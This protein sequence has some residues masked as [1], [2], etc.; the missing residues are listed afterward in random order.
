MV[1]CEVDHLV[2]HQGFISVTDCQPI[3]VGHDHEGRRAVPAMNDLDVSILY[4]SRFFTSC[5]FD[6]SHFTVKV[7]KYPVTALTPPPPPAPP[8][9]PRVR[10]AG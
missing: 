2:G 4:S 9:P 1:K 5:Y 8:P 3:G 10:L 6:D 7:E